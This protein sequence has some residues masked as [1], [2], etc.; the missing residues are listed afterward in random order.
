MFLPDPGVV[1]VVL[2]TVVANRM[3]GDPVWLL[4]IGPPSSGKT[5]TVDALSDLP[6]VHPITTTTKAGLLT[7]TTAKGGTG[8]LLRELGD[9][10]VLVVKDFTTMLSEHSSTRSEVFG[11]LRE[12]HDGSVV[13]T[14]GSKGGQR[15]V[16]RGHAGA[17]A[18][19]TEAVD[20]MDMAA[21]G[22]RWM[23]YRLPAMTDSDRMITGLVAIE[24][25]DHQEEY[26][27]QRRKVVT[28]FFSTLH[29]PERLPS[30]SDDEQ[31]RLITLADLAT[32]CRSAVVRESWRR[33]VIEQVPQ[34]EE[35]P[36][37]L[38]ALGQ[39]S[40]ALSI[41]G[42]TDAERWRL[43]VKCALDGMH[44]LRRKVLDV[45]VAADCDLATATVAGRCRLPP[46]STRRH[47]EDLTA[48]GVLDLIGDDPE[49]WATSAGTRER[50]WAVTTGPPTGQVDMTEDQAVAA[51]M[52][53][54][55][56][57]EIVEVL[58]FDS[59]MPNRW[60]AP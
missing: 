49:R 36:R 39:I 33:D 7:G 24:N 3:A 26:R 4:V 43:L 37:L 5:Q 19:G 59:D 30:L 15:I 28:K 14:V 51:V 16:W 53:A 47:L 42:A 54:F 23:R 38:T 9:R 10:G 27:T 45:L 50:W 55:P 40:G 22:E 48:L 57:A 32:R 1:L 56:G 11:I 44:S 6:D 13:R 18:C 35:T 21:L 60:G 25:I 2:A 29:L 12:V 52:A 46:T 31:H 17:I 34:P 8:G 41:I 20:S 58:T